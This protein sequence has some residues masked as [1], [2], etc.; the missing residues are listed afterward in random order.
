MP[1]AKKNAGVAMDNNM[2]HI[3]L[4]VFNE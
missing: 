4:T 3:D 1:K 2:Y